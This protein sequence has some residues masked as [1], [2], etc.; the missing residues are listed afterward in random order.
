MLACNL[1]DAFRHLGR[2]KRDAARERSLEQDLEQS[3]SRLGSWLAAAEA[4]PSEDALRHEEAVR[5]AAALQAL[6]EAN[7]EAVVLRYYER[8]SLDDISARLGRT[9]AA[10]VGLLKRG[11]RQLR[12]IL[13]EESEP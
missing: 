4:S 7:R 1:A 13:H 3:S 10:V 12:A 8:L 9:P 5:V 11:L 2:A 6:P